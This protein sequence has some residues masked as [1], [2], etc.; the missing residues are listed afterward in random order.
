MSATRTTKLVA[1]L[2][3]LVCLGCGSSDRIA[4]D[5]DL[6]GMWEAT[7]AVCM[8]DPLPEN[9]NLPPDLPPGASEQIRRLLDPARLEDGLEG[10]V[11]VVQTGDVLEIFEVEEVEA[12]AFSGTVTGNSLEY[13]LSQDGVCIEG[14]GVIVSPDR[15]EIDHVLALEEFG[16]TVSCEFDVVRL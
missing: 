16:A 5:H 13:S 1:L 9:L 4:P 7:G 8:S 2:A 11:R 10:A 14:E 15:L 12:E 6:T 3:V